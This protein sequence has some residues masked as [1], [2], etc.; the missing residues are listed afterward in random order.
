MEPDIRGECGVFYDIDGFII[1]NK[2]KSIRKRFGKRWA[3]SNSETAAIEKK[4]RSSL[5]ARNELK[6]LKKGKSGFSIVLYLPSEKSKVQS[7]G[8]KITVQ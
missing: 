3:S 4:I 2:A 7:K 8:C 5:R 1:S 6:Y